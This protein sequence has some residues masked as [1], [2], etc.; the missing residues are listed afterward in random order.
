V[1]VVFLKDVEGSGRI[2][3][4]KNVANGYA[5]NY[6]LPKGLAAPATPDAIKK[7]EARAIVEA[8][9]QALLDEAAQSVA[10]RLAG[11]SFTI[12]AKAGSKGRLFGSVT[13]ADIAD[14]VGKML[15][16]DV[17]RH[18][19]L[20]AEPIKET[21]G[22]EITIQLTKNV[23]PVVSVKVAAEGAPVEEQAAEAAPE[24]EEVESEPEEAEASEPETE[25]E[26]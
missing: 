16:H 7:A 12:I 18:Q 25:S 10:E 13:Q 15:G 22:Y 2:G 4:I 20:L 23:R 26:P 21:G 1:K 11:A 24:S 8:K 14:E 17:D 5:R 6:L 3:E 19:V 9:K